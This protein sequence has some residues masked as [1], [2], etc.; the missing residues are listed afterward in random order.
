MDLLL[1]NNCE[2]GNNDDDYND[3]NDD[4]DDD[5]DYD[6][7]DYIDDDGGDYVDDNYVIGGYPHGPGNPASPG[8]LSRKDCVVVDGFSEALCYAFRTDNTGPP[9]SAEVSDVAVSE[10]RHC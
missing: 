7:D 3:Y 6:G 2:I 9:T 1:E 8:G 4:G 10:I 5:D